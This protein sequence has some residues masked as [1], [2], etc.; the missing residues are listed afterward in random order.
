MTV[1][2][3]YPLDSQKHAGAVFKGG[4]YLSKNSSTASLAPIEND[5]QS[6][7][8]VRIQ[9][10][11]SRMNQVTPTLDAD[12][13]SNGFGSRLEKIS[14][15]D[16]GSRAAQRKANFEQVYNTYDRIYNKRIDYEKG[17][18]DSAGSSG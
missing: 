16:A 5:K 10:S 3:Q 9:D 13:Q 2:N 8:Y 4:Q 7:G 18:L 15:G 14:Q 17:T 12:N 1:L 11:M 6:D